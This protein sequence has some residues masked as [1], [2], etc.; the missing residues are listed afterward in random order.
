MRK[1]C[2]HAM[3]DSLMLNNVSIL[4][5]FKDNL[6]MFYQPQIRIYVKHN[7][8]IQEAINFKILYANSASQLLLRKH[9]TDILFRAE[10]QQ[11]VISHLKLGSW[12]LL[13]IFVKI[14]AINQD[15][16]T[17]R[18]QTLARKQIKLETRFSQVPTYSD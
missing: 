14:F 13:A 4:Y 15:N 10:N 9:Y 16:L 3:P 7:Q 18:T 12:C 6:K 8:R 2:F 17:A 5:H 1:H 11:L